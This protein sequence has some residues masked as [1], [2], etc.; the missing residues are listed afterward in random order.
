MMVLSKDLEKKGA[1]KEGVEILAQLVHPFAPHLGEEMW[2]MLGHPPSIQNVAWPVAEA[3]LLVD[4][5]V[6]IPVQI[7]G[8]KRE[9]IKLPKDIDEAGAVAAA[10]ALPRI[11]AAFEEGTLRKTIWVPGR[12]LNFII[13]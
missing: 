7:N 4:D 13:K 2:E 5:E 6:N 12:I 1:P 8:K 9:L 11:A 3:A 10:K